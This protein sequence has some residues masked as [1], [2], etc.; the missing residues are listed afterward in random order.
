M[1]YILTEEEYTELKKTRKLED[2]VNKEKLQ[3]L[4]TLVANHAPAT[5]PWDK[6]NTSPWHCGINSKHESY[7]DHCPCQDLCPNP[8]KEWSK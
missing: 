5:R 3:E 7:C 2:A 8:F 4:C 6:E 1:Q